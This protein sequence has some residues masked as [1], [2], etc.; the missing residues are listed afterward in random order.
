[1]CIAVI[2]TNY[3]ARYPLI[4]VHNREEDIT[5][6]TSDLFLHDNILSAVDLKAGGI[7]AVGLNITT[8]QFAVLTNCRMKDSF[9]PDGASRGS[10]LKQILI[11]GPS[12]GVNHRIN[13]E[14][15]QGGF[16]VYTGNSFINHEFDIHY[17]SNIAS[18]ISWRHSFES[19]R[20]DLKIF[21][22]MNEHPNSVCDWKPKLD[23]VESRILSDVSINRSMESVDDIIN[24]VL[25][26][27][28]NIEQLP[29]RSD[30]SAYDWSPS[31]E[32]EPVAQAHIVIPATQLSS[33][34]FGTV[35]QTI[36]VTDHSAKAV[37]YRYRT[38][39]HENKPVFNS[40]HNCV[41]KYS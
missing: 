36:L 30:K 34:V 12:A 13:S 38:I 7:A 29:A 31:P 17:M 33:C 20:G 23:H 37:H 27:L 28:S 41:I 11:E 16:H 3:S 9:H 24:T 19:S 8:G 25:L 10:I 21:V 18:N 32:L 4:V 15:F 35:S 40:W 14:V 26:S 5:R 2:I 1:M 6:P 39:T 22:T